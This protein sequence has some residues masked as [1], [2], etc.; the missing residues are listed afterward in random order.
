M[1]LQAWGLG[2]GS[3]GT[4]QLLHPEMTYIPRMQNHLPEPCP[5][6]LTRDLTYRGSVDSPG[7]CIFPSLL[8]PLCTCHRLSSPI[9]A[10]TSRVLETMS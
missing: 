8:W 1:W 7:C 6:I 2:G 5:Y 10:V 3:G 4:P 9:Q